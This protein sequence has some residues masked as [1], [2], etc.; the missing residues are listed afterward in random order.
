[1]G[2]PPTSSMGDRDRRGG[3]ERDGQEKGILRS[4]P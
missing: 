2:S 1:M 3:S 4:S